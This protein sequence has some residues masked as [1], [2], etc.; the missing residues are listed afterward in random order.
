MKYGLLLLV[1]AVPQIALAQAS[2]VYIT[3]DGAGTQNGT[4]LAN[5]GA[6][7]TAPGVAQMTCA[8]FNS[9][10][11]W[12]TGSKQIGPGTVV[13]LGSDGVM[14]AASAGATSY[15]QFQA[16]GASGNVIE[17]LFDH[18]VMLSAPYFN[19]AIDFNGQSYVLVDGGTAC[20]TGT[21]C[22]SG[23][24]GTGAIQN[25]QNGTA[26][27]YQNATNGINVGTGS[28]LEIRNLLIL[29][30]YIRTSG[31]ADESNGATTSSGIYGTPGSN[32]LI[33]DLTSTYSEHNISLGG[34]NTS[35]SNW[36]IYNCV[37]A[38]QV[39]GI[40]TSTGNSNQTVTGV[41]IYGNNVNNGQEW[42]EASAGTFHF[43]GIFVYGQGSVDGSGSVD[44][45]NIYNNYV[46]G[47]WGT[48]AGSPA[49]SAFVYTNG[50]LHGV[51]LF[52]NIL[53]LTG[54]G[55]ADALWYYGDYISN[56]LFANNTVVGFYSGGGTS[57]PTASLAILDFLSGGTVTG[58]ITI[59]NNIFWNMG[60]AVH[61]S[62]SGSPFDYNFYG[63]LCHKYMCGGP[64]DYQSQTVSTNYFNLAQASADGYPAYNNWQTTGNDVHGGYSDTVLNSG[65]FIPP[66]GSIATGAANNFYSICNGQPNP[67]LGA[68]CYDASGN[69][70]PSQPTAKWDAGAYQSNSKAANLLNPPTSVTT[71]GH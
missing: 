54:T 63:G 52:N 51:N 38:H 10:S 8:F 24:S 17:L 58:P 56:V 26:L 27:T 14:I 60:W 19:R 15:L 43:D 30:M 28:N 65:S 32:V 45:V 46:W 49:E 71:T 59:Q 16:S 1:L 3:R 34:T 57:S 2:A 64:G 23:L 62:Y 39:W 31:S 25:T 13:H 47:N 5:A 42:N 53:N 4:S 12:G 66:S 20:G 35:A 11:N 7:D 55:V 18:N 67:G 29:N 70:R 48:N 33:H 6:C 40:N 61:V 41:N 44:N 9:P 21:T 68:L 37:V 36:N 50:N 22:S 69:M